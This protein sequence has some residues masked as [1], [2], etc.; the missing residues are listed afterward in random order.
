MPGKRSLAEVSD[1][2][3]PSGPSLLPS[4]HA[5]PPILSAAD[6][7]IW[8]TCTSRLQINLFIVDHV[9]MS[10]SNGRGRLCFCE[11]D[12]CNAATVTTTAAGGEGRSAMLLSAVVFSIKGASINDVST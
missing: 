9:C 11:E 1:E 4:F 5:V 8:R 7:N 10:Q 3:R 6:Y 12:N 2:G